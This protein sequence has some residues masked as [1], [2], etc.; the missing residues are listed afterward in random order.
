MIAGVL[1]QIGAGMPD[2][3]GSDRMAAFGTYALSPGRER[4]RRMAQTLGRSGLARRAC[5]LIRRIVA[6]GR[7]GPF[8]V[9]AFPGQRA[10]LYPAENL[11]DKRVFAGV[12]FWDW[13]ER[14]AL[15]RAI[16]A[17]PG[18]AY[19]VDAGANAGLYTLAALAAGESKPVNVL[20]VEPDPENLARLGFNLAAS[21]ASTVTVAPFGLADC[22]GTAHLAAAH[23]N[24]G[25]LALADR[26]TEITLRP[27]ADLVAEAGFP[28]LDVL[29]IDIEGMEAAVLDHYFSHSGPP[30]W[31][32]LVIL[33][34]PRGAETEALG[35]L[36]ARGYRIDHRTRLNAV[37]SRPIGPSPAQ[38]DDANG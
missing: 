29:K 32:G 8:D 9:E 13:C 3:T 24:R 20:A 37:L 36:T 34:A 19:M 12:Q 33:E 17:A 11:S 7:A 5:S 38:T 15:A 18:P 4:L 25:E 28:R 16:R 30:L 6:A 26:G 14:A 31:P 2:D 22:T 1:R 27:L 23:A 35:A 10:R 21:G